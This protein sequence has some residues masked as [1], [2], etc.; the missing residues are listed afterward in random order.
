MK[1]FLDGQV[2]EYSKDLNHDN[3]VKWIEFNYFCPDGNHMSR[4]G[5]E[6]ILKNLQPFSTKQPNL[7]PSKRVTRPVMQKD[8]FN[9]SLLLHIFHVL[10]SFWA[11]K[12]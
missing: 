7:L 4:F 11:K 5:N 1:K 3:I 10:I 6:P 9:L 8:C 2:E 12:L